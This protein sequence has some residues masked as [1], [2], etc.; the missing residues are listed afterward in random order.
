MATGFLCK[1]LAQDHY[2]RRLHFPLR[3][4]YRAAWTLAALFQSPQFHLRQKNNVLRTLQVLLRI[5]PAQKPCPSTVRPSTVSL[6]TVLRS[7]AY[8]P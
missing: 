4:L 3:H 8:R 6:S 5:P 1:V 2:L 7:L